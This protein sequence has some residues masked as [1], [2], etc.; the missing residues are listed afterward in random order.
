VTPSP[1]DAALLGTLGEARRL[2]FLGPGALAPQLE[3]ALGFADALAALPDGPAPGRV[4]DLGSGGGLPG[5]VLATRWPEAALVLVE[6]G[7]RRAAFLTE[8][9]TRLGLK[10]RVTVLRERAEVAGRDPGRRGCFD[11]VVSRSFGPP[12][13]T[14]ECAAPFLRVGGVLVASGP[15]DPGRHRE[16]W[17]VAGLAMVGLGAPGQ[18]AGVF[19][20]ELA[21]QLE[22]CPERFPRRTGIP[23]KRP[24]F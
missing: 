12:A 16:R 5:L 3:H 17:P 19:T 8:A 15:P 21:R 4:V 18:S 24:L 6:A 14:A 1:P 23:T 9:V 11:V 20:Y 7:G 22:P 10:S 13:V 2:G